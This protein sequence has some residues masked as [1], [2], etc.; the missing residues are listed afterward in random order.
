[1]YRVYL[2]GLGHH[3]HIY[4]AYWTVGMDLIESVVCFLL[5]HHKVIGEIITH[6]CQKLGQS[7]ILFTTADHKFK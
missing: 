4:L 5:S 7:V 2:V 6:R 3:V 1:M